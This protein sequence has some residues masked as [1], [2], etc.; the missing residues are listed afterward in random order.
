MN[1][2]K[3]SVAVARLPCGAT[4]APAR[5]ARGGQE[6]GTAQPAMLAQRRERHPGLSDYPTDAQSTRRSTYSLWSSSPFPRLLIDELAAPPVRCFVS[7][8]RRCVQYRKQRATRYST[9]DCVRQTA[10]TAARIARNDIFCF[11]NVS[12]WRFDALGACRA[13]RRNCRI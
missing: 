12:Q 1:R 3:V 4:T 11:R 7:T 2:M 13:P 8:A 6:T 10:A 5:E 9:G